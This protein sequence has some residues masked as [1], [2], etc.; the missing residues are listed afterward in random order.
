MLDDKF[1]ITSGFKEFLKKRKI[2]FSRKSFRKYLTFTYKQKGI[3][4]D[5]I[6]DTPKILEEIMWNLA[7]VNFIV[8][9][10]INEEKNAN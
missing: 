4:S 6:S 7:L 2:G 3:N 5:E 10:W 8:V 9:E 1:C